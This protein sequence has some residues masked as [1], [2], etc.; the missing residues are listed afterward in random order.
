MSR[1]TL[2]TLAAAVGLGAIV[3]VTVAVETV[4]SSCEERQFNGW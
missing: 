1:A 2:A 3:G 4:A